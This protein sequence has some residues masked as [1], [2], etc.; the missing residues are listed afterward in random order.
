ML[1]PAG[2][3]GT[4]SEVRDRLS[5]EIRTE[6]IDRLV[7]ESPAAEILHL[8]LIS[9]VAALFWDHVPPIALLAWVLA[10]TAS[11]LV[12]A[13]VRHVLRTQG[14]ERAY[15]LT[16]VRTTVLAS[17]LAWAVGPTIVT[18]GLELPDLSLVL[19]IFSGLVAGGTVT[20]I[21]DPRSFY[22]F[23]AGLLGPLALAIVVHGQERWH[24]IALAVMTVFAVA[25]VVL[26]RRSHGQFLDYLTAAKRLAISEAQSARER[27]FLDALLSSAPTAI[28]AVSRDGKVLGANPAF[29]QLFGYPA[30]EAQGEELND[31][32]VPESERHAARTLDA[33]V[34][35]G[36][37]VVEEVERR[38]KDGKHVWV[39]ASA[40]SVQE[41]IGGGATF[42]LYEN[43][44]QRKLAEAALRRAEEMYRDLVESASDLVWEVDRAGHWTFLN[45]AAR[46]IYGIDPAALTDRPFAERVEP[47]HRETDQAAF[48]QVLRGGELTDYETVHLDTEGKPRHLSFAARPVMGEDGNVVGI[49]GTARDVTERAVAR[50]TLEE[51]RQLAERAAQAKGAFLA[52]MSHEIRT[53][54]NAVLGMTELLLDTELLPEQRSSAEL[55]KSS[56]EAL[57]SVINDILDF[58]KIEAGH[59][60]L[61]EIEFD[62]RGL[63]DSVVRLH[64][65]TAFH[66]GIELAYD[67]GPTVPRTVRG[68]PSRLRQVL[69][70]LLGNAL[71]FTEEGEVVVTLSLASGGGEQAA[72]EFCVRD[73]GIGIAADQIEKMFAEFTQADVSTTRRYGGTGLGLAITRR[74]VRLMGG[75]DVVVTSEPGTG[76]EF[77]FAATFPVVGQDSGRSLPRDSTALR[78]ARVLIADDNATIQ[79]IVGEALGGLGASVRAVG[80][81]EAALAAVREGSSSGQLYHLAIVDAYMPGMGGFELAEVIREDQELGGLKLMMLTSVGQRG[82]GERCRALG[83]AA[84]LPKPVSE[85]ELVEAASAVLVGEGVLRRVEEPARLVTR[86]SMAEARRPLRILVAEDNPVNQQVARRMLEKRGHAVEIVGNGREAVTAVEHGEYDVVLMDIQM[87][88]MD[89]ITATHEIRRN[90][91]Y[92]DLPIIAMTAHALQEERQHFLAEGMN[93]HIPKPFKPHELFSCV[94]G[95]GGGGGGTVEA[96]TPAQVVPDSSQP[97]DLESF[98]RT[99]REAGVEEAVDG[100]LDVFMGDA[101]GRMEAVSVAVASGDAEQ[102]RLAAHAFKS[103]AGTVEARRLF[104]LLK[105]LET[106][107]RE[108]RTDEA[109]QL[110]ELV[111]AEYAAVHAYLEQAR[112]A[113]G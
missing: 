37:I 63:V 40:A 3:F 10:V 52:N 68:D 21:A 11:V 13:Y 61:E 79:R 66:K 103:A 31:L 8:V 33:Q 56:A 55:V 64:A 25:M 107:G 75:E 106:A 85:T 51:A 78:Q 16:A 105:Q 35:S 9:I 50:E 83:I 87:P 18:G 98:R 100:M 102:T 59:L 110:H 96:P 82:D 65:L 76:S 58:S 80:S 39:Q 95:W 6:L 60:E 47:T 81:A 34:R 15:S 26:Y 71:K 45:A 54:M 94:E 77:G 28:A 4:E 32:I 14:S 24:V 92:A 48:L 89:G 69:N 97:V 99:M 36:R 73:T 74:L 1:A 29:E 19:V 70:N 12:R 109:E 104:E 108:R 62:L 20:L 30:A 112:A 46:Q 67:I 53:P 86:H 84:Y 57:L 72:V 38:R 49:R 17:A 7:A 2:T 111:A 42:V 93:D 41:E 27:G 22:A 101:P 88:E 5:A 44:T 91:A 43:V 113:S 23:S 90:P